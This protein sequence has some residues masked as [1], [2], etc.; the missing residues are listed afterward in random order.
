MAKKKPVKKTAAKK[1]APRKP[2][3]K[4][5]AAKQAAAKKPVAKKT[6]AKK[7]AAKQPPAKASAG[8]AW[9]KEGSKA[10]DFTATAHDGTKVTLAAL[11]GRPV[12]LYFYPKDDTPGCTVEACGFRDAHAQFGRHKA[13]VLGVS[14]DSPRSHEKFRTKF[15]LP[16][17][18]LADER[19]ELAEKYG[20][21]REKSMYGKAFM[22]IARST[23]VIDAAGRI[24]KVFTGV[25]PEGHDREVLAAVA[26]LR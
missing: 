1:T 6:S 24:A 18:L 22:G 10:P 2:A 19:H 14:P 15:K 17:T 5:P 25:K 20:A 16:F 9:P 4:K 26:A 11:K 3:A 12:V 13:V 23:F 8:P 21:W 7:P